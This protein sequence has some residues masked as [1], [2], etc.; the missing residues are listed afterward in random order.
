MGRYSVPI[1]D[2]CSILRLGSIPTIKGTEKIIPIA[3]STIDLNILPEI[4][5]SKDKIKIDNKLILEKAPLKVKKVESIHKS[6][7]K[8]PQLNM[9]KSC[10]N[11]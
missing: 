1:S 4:R 5:I 9:T 6:Q 11:S 7:S 2:N 10:Q 8:N 3:K